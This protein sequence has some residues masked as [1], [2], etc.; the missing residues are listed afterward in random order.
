[1]KHGTGVRGG[2]FPC[3]RARFDPQ[4]IV[5]RLETLGKRHS[6][7]PTTMMRMALIRPRMLRRYTNRAS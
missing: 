4:A 2:H 6:R 7:A 1:M 5:D 3:R